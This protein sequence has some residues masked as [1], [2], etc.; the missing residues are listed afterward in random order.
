[1][2]EFLSTRLGRNLAIL[3]ILTILA[4]PVACLGTGL[5]IGRI[6]SYIQSRAEKPNELILKWEK[7]GDD[8]FVKVRIQGKWGW[9][10]VDTGASCT[11]VS[12]F[13]PHFLAHTATSETEN[14]FFGFYNQSVK[15]KV[16][17]IPNVQLE[18]WRIK[19]L[20]ANV[21]DVVVC[22]PIVIDGSPVFGWIG[23]DLLSRWRVVKMTKHHLILSDAPFTPPPTA[24]KFRMSLID[25]R[26]HVIA[27]FARNQP[28]FWLLDTGVEEHL[29]SSE[30]FRHIDKSLFQRVKNS[31]SSG[32]IGMMT[33]EK[34]DAQG[35]Q[36]L[37]VE[38]E[39]IKSGSPPF[40]C[41]N[42]SEEHTCRSVIIGNS[43][44][45]QYDVVIDNKEM[46]IYFIPIK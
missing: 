33:I 25:R 16:I 45:N 2:K 41:S 17:Y 44:L 46:M 42:K 5:A 23:Y 39:V 11:M 35:R 34:S 36:T 32:A 37:K 1:M 10:Q 43:I 4:I 13:V 9:M 14:V 15:S 22:Y 40:V 18:K 19:Q 3:A 24:A 21:S 12:A 29:I 27:E 31:S 8:Y 6:L 28:Q 38:G 7:V 30:V 20:R 26:P